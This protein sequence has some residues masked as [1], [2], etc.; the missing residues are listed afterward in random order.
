MTHQGY[1]PSMQGNGSTTRPPAYNSFEPSFTSAK[2]AGSSVSFSSQT[3][4]VQW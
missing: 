2:Y 1:D 3:K 4:A